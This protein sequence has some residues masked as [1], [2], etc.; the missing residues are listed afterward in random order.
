[1][2]REQDADGAGKVNV[3]VRVKATA[4]ATEAQL[5]KYA[6]CQSEKGA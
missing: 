4:G 2:A 1:V 3:R 5:N 6:R